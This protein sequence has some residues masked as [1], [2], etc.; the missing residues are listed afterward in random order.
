MKVPHCAS[1]NNGIFEV[2]LSMSLICFIFLFQSL[3]PNCTA[4]SLGRA[5]MAQVA[6]V[7]NQREGVA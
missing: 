4:T 7:N 1:L 5:A 3:E 6:V 2:F